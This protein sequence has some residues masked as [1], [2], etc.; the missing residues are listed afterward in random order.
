[1]H[2][3]GIHHLAVHARAAG[4]ERVAAFYRDVLGLPELAR[5]LSPQGGLRSIW[6]SLAASGD[7]LAGFLAVEDGDDFGPAMVA[8]RIRAA[9][10]GAL[11]AD[12]LARGIAVEKQTRWT[13]Y[14]EDPAG[15]HVAFSHHPHDPL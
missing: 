14:V 12:F 1:M 15:N 11:L 3:L 4:V 5:N 7:P 9:D 8:L 13:V 2:S 10:R 6:L